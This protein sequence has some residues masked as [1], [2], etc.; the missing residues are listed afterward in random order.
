[1]SGQETHTND[2]TKHPYSAPESARERLL[3]ALPVSERR[4]QLNEIPTAVLEGGSGPPVILLH[5]PGG[6]GAQWLRVIPDLVKT[7]RVI[8]PDLPGHGASGISDGPL[9]ADRMIGWLDDLI[10]CTCDST[11]VIVGHV[12][13]GAIAARFAAESSERLSKLVLVDSLGLTD[14]Q[15]A[16][17]F[18]Q[19]LQEFM[20]SPTEAAHDRLWNLCA[21]NLDAL[22]DGLGERWQW[23]KAYNMERAATPAQ[24]GAMHNLMQ[25]FGFPAIP[26]AA[27]ERITVPTRLIWGRHDL[28]TPVRVAEAASSR[29]SW[30]LHIIEDAAD[31]PSLDQP[32]AFLQALRAAIAQSQGD[33]PVVGPGPDTRPAWDRIA[34][35]YDRTNTPTQMQIAGE[36][37]RRAGLRPGMRFLDV[38]AGS[39]ALSIPA[40]RMG[41]RVLATDQSPAMLGLLEKRSRQEALNIKTRVMDG[42][43]LD[44]DDNSFDMAGSQFGVMLF[45]DMLRGVR[46]MTR[47]VKPGGRVLILAYG[48]PHQ[49]EFLGF[50]VS[51]VQSVRPD[52][53]GPPQDPP[54][55]EFQLSNPERLREALSAAGLK[56]VDVE[57]VV[58]TT[59][60]R[61]GKDLWEWIIW[62]NPIAEMILSDQ[63]KLSPGERM[64]VQQ[65]LETMVRD[66]AGSGDAARLTNPV[67]IGVGVR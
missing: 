66:R 13:G 1:M 62:S 40:A 20:S 12:L 35:G 47:A 36:G 24:G 52:F 30:P 49:I 58:E 9:D 32:E 50:L 46:E 16:P 59:E 48:D 3:A 26:T 53:D 65:A 38:A 25:A 19:A 29:H 8:A 10:E 34:P 6:Y 28:A 22:R 43:A 45:P 23:I 2:E 7:H 37:L 31:D 4:L 60:H 18:G 42:H 21:H 54:P 11:P 55:L 67:N 27:L 41:A 14:F 57:T 61:T 15:P 56:N 33:A 39:G 44:L 64:E 51:A 63:L 17:E 5:G